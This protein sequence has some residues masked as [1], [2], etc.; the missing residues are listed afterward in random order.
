VGRAER[1]AK[2]V[3]RNPLVAALTGT[4]FAAVFAILGLSVVVAVRSREA[5]Q[6]DHERFLQSLVSQAQA[7]RRA[8]ERQRSLELLAEAA[9]ARPTDGLRQ[10]AIQTIATPGVRLLSQM[11]PKSGAEKDEE[12]FGPVYSQDGN[13]V[14]FAAREEDIYQKQPSNGKEVSAGTLKPV[15]RVREFGSGKLLARR[16]D[17]VTPLR[18]RPTTSHLAI[19]GG[20]R[21]PGNPV[22]SLWDPISGKDLGAYQGDSPVFSAD[23]AFL[24]TVAGQ[25]VRIWNL[26][27]GGEAKP[28]QRGNPLQF[29]SERELLLADGGSYRRWDFILG[30]ETSTTP[31][32]FAGLAVS[33]S[34][35]LAVL[36]GRPAP[37]S[38]RGVGLDRMQTGGPTAGPGLCARLSFFLA[39]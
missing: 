37:G 38:H 15:L 20:A 36:P 31:K 18:F 34:G 29:L 22:T 33:A 9:R 4:A 21:A 10:E 26:A 27:Q 6:R 12:V 25:Q 11:S 35:R 3:R 17:L 13:L 2:W 16:S 24:A 39:R 14:A 5:A 7:E 19:A 8:G 30:R 28:R 32:G 23:G 1:V